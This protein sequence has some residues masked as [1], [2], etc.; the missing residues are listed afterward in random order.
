MS[1]QAWVCLK[2]TALMMKET[3][4]FCW[5]ETKSGRQREW[6][7]LQTKRRQQ[8]NVSLLGTNWKSK[9]LTKLQNTLCHLLNKSIK[10]KTK[11]I[12]WMTNKKAFKC[13]FSPLG[14]S[15]KGNDKLKVE[16]ANRITN[17]M[18]SRLPFVEQKHAWSGIA[19]EY[20]KWKTETKRHS[21]V[22]LLNFA[23][24]AK[25]DGRLKVGGANRI[26]NPMLSLLNIKAQKLCQSGKPREYINF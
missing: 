13:Y 19:R 1:S 12:H 7:K 15:I 20:I 11:R 6:I 25:D 14:S 24:L 4:F 9:E 8:S 10:W 23:L 16:I 2:L 21:N 26:A 3:C 17:N 5:I 18:Y 22:A